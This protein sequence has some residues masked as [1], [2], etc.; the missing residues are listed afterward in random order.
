[1]AIREIV[2]RS[3]LHSAGDW[4]VEVSITNEGGMQASAS[5]PQGQSSGSREAVYVPPRQATANVSDVIAPA[6]AGT[7]TDQQRSFDETLID[8]DG[9]DRKAN[10]GANAILGASIAYAKLSAAEQDETLAGYLQRQY[11]HVAEAQ[12]PALLANMVEGGVHAGGTLPFQEYLVRLPRTDVYT[13]I[14]SAVSLYQQ[15]RTTF[16]EQGDQRALNVGMEG[17]FTPAYEQSEDV[18]HLFRDAAERCGLEDISYG[19]DVAGGAQAG[20]AQERHDT[21]VRLSQQF[22]LTMIEDPFDEDDFE[23]HHTLQQEVG[24]SVVIVGDDLTVT[25][26]TRMRE[27]QEARAVTG[28]IVKP[29]QIGTLSETFDAVTMAREWG[30]DVI[31]SH[32]GSDT[33]DDWIADI[34]VA[35]GADGFKIGSPARG[36]RVAKYNRLLQLATT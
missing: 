2:A 15:L 13:A 32:R 29:N 17:G 9:D 8:I 34:A 18:F 25:N 12:P 26:I 16:T 1:M 35:V 14:R 21:L 4:T 20:T 28:M 27:A 10:L 22:P 5:V 24:N 33:N 3:I 23:A 36:E 30:W 7:E 19:V 11:P 6:V 31:C